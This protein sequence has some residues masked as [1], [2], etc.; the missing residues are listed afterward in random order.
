[1]INTLASVNGSTRKR[2]ND[3]DTK[4]AEYRIFIIIRPSPTTKKDN[5]DFSRD[6]VYHVILY[7][8][9]SIF[10]QANNLK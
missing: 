6:D 7:S 1:M 10:H 2:A 8:I 5:H 4:Y 3:D 9:C